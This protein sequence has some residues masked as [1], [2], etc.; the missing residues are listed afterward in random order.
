MWERG[1]IVVPSTW[2]LFFNCD[3]LNEAS[4]M[5]ICMHCFFGKMSKYITKDLCSWKV[6]L[7]YFKST[8]NF[9]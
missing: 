9:I 5:A 7:L 6:S 2:I 4:F 3:P 1:L 8:R